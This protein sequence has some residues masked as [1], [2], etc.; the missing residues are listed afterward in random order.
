MKLLASI[1]TGLLLIGGQP[2][3]EKSASLYVANYENVL[4]TSLTLKFV[5]SS[6]VEAEKAETAALGEISRLSAI[7]S[8]YDSHSEFSKWLSQDL[9]QPTKVSSELFQMLQLFERWRQRTGGALDASTAVASKLWT[10]AA[11]YQKL[12]SEAQ[13]RQAVYTMQQKHFLLDEHNLTATRLTSAPLVMNSFAKSYILNL[14]CDAAIKAA[15]I[16]AAVVNI[17]GDLVVKGELNDV[18]KVTNPQANA[19]NDKPLDQLLV[20]DMAIATS[21]NYRRGQQIGNHWYT[22]IIDPRTAKPV[23]GIISATVVAKNATD[24][25]ALATAFNILSIPESKALAATIAGAEY[26]IITAKGERVESNGWSTLVDPATKEDKALLVPV[27]SHAEKQWDPKYELNI[28]LE[29]NVIA[30]NTQAG[31]KSRA[32]V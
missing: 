28:T 18:V 16:D 9:H 13:L 27:Y 8:A 30:G 32:L 31:K 19:E 15:K 11:K 29:L 22:H 10:E 24:A 26:L 4:G 7:F 17:G 23:E 2:Y 20:H 6:E 25:G 3:R 14:A 1:L 5:S 21:G 12:P